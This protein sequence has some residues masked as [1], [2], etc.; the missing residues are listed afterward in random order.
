MDERLEFE[1]WVADMEP[2]YAA[3]NLERLTGGRG[4]YKVHNVACWWYAWQAR[5]ELEKKV[6][7]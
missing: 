1:K 6:V 2:A 7:K 5:A 4:G 3:E